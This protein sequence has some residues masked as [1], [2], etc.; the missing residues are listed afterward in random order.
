MRFR[1]HTTSDDEDDEEEEEEEGDGK[2]GRMMHPSLESEPGSAIP[3]G[4]AD[5]STKDPIAV[6]PLP[7]PS[8]PGPGPGS[9][10]PPPPPLPPPSLR[11]S[12]S[13]RV[14]VNIIDPYASHGAQQRCDQL[15]TTLPR[16]SRRALLDA[17]AAHVYAHLGASSN[18]GARPLS[19]RK[20]IRM[21]MRRARMDGVMRDMT[22]FRSD[23]LTLFFMRGGGREGGVPLFEVEAESVPSGT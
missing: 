19:Q 18:Q 5:S 8:V 16:P 14:H 20:T 10:T 21:R 9:A 23:D 4:L 1:I 3:T 22:G 17:V 6:H 7:I 15:V 12:S 13:L 2:E 11:P